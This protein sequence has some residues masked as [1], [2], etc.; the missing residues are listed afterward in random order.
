[1]WTNEA[2]VGMTPSRLGADELFFF[3]MLLALVFLQH[4]VIEKR[5]YYKYI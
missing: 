2:L 1:M 5:L 4:V 3:S